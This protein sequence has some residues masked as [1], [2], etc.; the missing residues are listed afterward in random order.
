M[1]QNLE[2]PRTWRAQCVIAEAVLTAPDIGSL[3]AHA[4]GNATDGFVIE[5]FLR[6]PAQE[7]LG[8]LPA[9]TA[10]IFFAGDDHVGTAPSNHLASSG[11]T[12]W[13]FASMP[14]RF[15]GGLEVTPPR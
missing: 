15:E 8:R 4:G 7:R 2:L 13:Q 6:S 12:L 9:R 1:T 10:V 5:A 14:S 3:Q 11:G